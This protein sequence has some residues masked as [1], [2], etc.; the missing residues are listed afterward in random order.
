ML[1]LPAL[2][3]SPLAVSWLVLACGLFVLMGCGGGTKGTAGQAETKEPK[4]DEPIR[5]GA[6]ANTP[7]KDV[8]PEDAPIKLGPGPGDTKTPPKESRKYT[9]ED[10]R[11]ALNPLQVMVGGWQGSLQKAAEFDSLQWAWDFKTDR[12]QPALV[13]NA[14]KGVAV[15]SGR[16]TYLPADEAFV[17]KAVDPEGRE[18]TLT[19][20]FTQTPRKVAG[21]DNRLHM[22]YK[23]EVTEEDAPDGAKPWQVVF[24]QQNNNRLLVEMAE[25]TGQN[26]R[27]VE[28]FA[29]QRE[30]TSFARSFDDYGDRTCIVSQGLGTDTVT[31][32]GKTYYVCCS[33]CKAAFE[34][35]PEY[36][37]AKAA[38]REAEK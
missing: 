3:R 38:E 18:R 22:T 17:L 6:A 12:K 29:V 21:D 33:G 4:E 36:W 26:F 27:R 25:R 20:A 5:L 19:G 23:L 35:D 16:L 8:P 7:K 11:Q 14:M 31:H 1:A 28:T 32:M 37:I 24:N 30:G 13:F 34:D 9:T 10:V 15:K 2:H